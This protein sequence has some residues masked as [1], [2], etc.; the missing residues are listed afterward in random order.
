[1]V[2]G[3][4]GQHAIRE[5]VRIPGD[6]HRGLQRASLKASQKSGEMQRS[7]FEGRQESGGSRRPGFEAAQ[8]WGGAYL[9]EGAMRG[10][11]VEGVG[12]MGRSQ[13]RFGS[14]GAAAQKGGGRHESTE[15]P[16]GAGAGGS[17]GATGGV[18]RWDFG[19]GQEGMRRRGDQQWDFGGGAE[20]VQR[21]GVQRGWDLGGA[22]EG[23]R[24]RGVQYETAMGQGGVQ[25]PP[26]VGAA[27]SART[28][29]GTGRA[30]RRAEET[31][32]E[33]NVRVRVLRQSS[34]RISNIVYSATCAN[35]RW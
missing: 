6:L 21:G 3:R 25:D 12:E 4:G 34:R 16:F 22:T 2:G 29:E 27:G 1:V 35:P 30:K 8:R 31:H 5:R 23:V 17:Y 24:R 33:V 9:G 26:G 15:A 32:E 28:V 11:Q 20:G 10:G 14:G 19:T 13:V 18:Q 7:R